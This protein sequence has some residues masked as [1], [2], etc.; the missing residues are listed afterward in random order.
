MIFSFS[1][2][3]ATILTSPLI[4]FIAELASNALVVPVQT[5]LTPSQSIAPAMFGSR[6]LRFRRI[7]QPRL[8]PSRGPCR[9][10]VRLGRYFSA[11]RL[12]PSSIP[13]ARICFIP[14]IW[15]A[16]HRTTRSRWPWIPAA[17]CT[18]PE[19][20]NRRISPQRPARSRP[21][22]SACNR[23]SPAMRATVF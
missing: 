21:H 3:L 1:A 2:S 13:R 15:A 22:M 5:T 17:L 8:A 18:S 23:I 4:A 20:L 6:E 16:T 7:S 14:L 11:T 12:L 9:A 10:Q 19:A